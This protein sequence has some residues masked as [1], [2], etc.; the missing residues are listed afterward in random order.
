MSMIYDVRHSRFQHASHPLRSFVQQIAHRAS[1]AGFNVQVKQSWSIRSLFPPFSIACIQV[2]WIY[3]NLRE[4]ERSIFDRDLSLTET[5]NLGE[6]FRKKFQ[7]C[8]AIV[9]IIARWI[10]YRSSWKKRNCR[11]DERRR[12]RRRKIKSRLIRMDGAWPR[13]CFRL[14]SGGNSRKERRS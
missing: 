14:Y 12:K 2:M 11:I 6:E 13:F 1:N 9:K 3:L 4:C 7:K 8:S 5:F 10:N